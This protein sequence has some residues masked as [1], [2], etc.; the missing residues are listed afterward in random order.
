MGLEPTIFWAT[1]R[2]VNPY[3]TPAILINLPIAIVILSHR[4][5]LG[6]KDL[7]GQILAQPQIP[8]RV[9]LLREGISEV[10]QQ[11]FTVSIVSSR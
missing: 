8:L 6:K 11:E 10:S 4:A 9:R 1:T 3:T 5:W 7:E 2:R